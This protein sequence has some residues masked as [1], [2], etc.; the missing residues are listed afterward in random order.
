ML[1]YDEI[2]YQHKRYTCKLFII[3]R[4]QIPKF[5]LFGY[6]HRSSQ[7]GGEGFETPYQEMNINAIHANYSLLVI[8]FH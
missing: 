2:K 7:R 3:G 8:H 5:T 6:C 1:V 4:T